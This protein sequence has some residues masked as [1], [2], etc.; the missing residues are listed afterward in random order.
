MRGPFGEGTLG[1]FARAGA[2]LMSTQHDRPQVTHRGV[3]VTRYDEH[4]LTQTDEYPDATGWYIDDTGQ[5]DVRNEDSK[6]HVVAS[7]P[8]DKW[9]RV[10]FPGAEVKVRLELPADEDENGEREDVEPHE[11]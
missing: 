8:G 3:R 10:W 6:C 11:G 1:Q 4:S 9:Q 7:Y 2:G 5:L